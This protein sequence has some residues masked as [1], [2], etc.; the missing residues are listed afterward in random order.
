MGYSVFRPLGV[1]HHVPRRAYTGFTLFT[2]LGGDTTYLVDM[3]GRV[4]HLWRPALPPYYGYFLDDGRLL[5]SLRLPETTVTFGGAHGAVA[6]LDWDG[7]IVWQ[8]ETPRST[9]TTPACRTATRWCC[10]GRPCPPRSRAAWPAASPA[11]RPRAA[12]CGATSWPR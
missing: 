6:E 9:T 1:T 3:Q 10:A 12:S 11:P 7:R 4:V 8:Y 2:T 5:T